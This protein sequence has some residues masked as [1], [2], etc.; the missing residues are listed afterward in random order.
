MVGALLKK[1]FS[2]LRLLLRRKG[3]EVKDG[4][5]KNREKKEKNKG[6]K[7]VDEDRKKTSYKK[8]KRKTKRNNLRRITWS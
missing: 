2:G 8:G 5:V 4:K 1:I 3:K 6:R 7:V